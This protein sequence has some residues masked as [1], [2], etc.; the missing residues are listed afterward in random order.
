MKGKLIWFISLTAG[1]VLLMSLVVVVLDPFFHYHAPLKK[2]Y[3][4]LDDERSQS[5]GVA[6]FFD[7]DAVITGAG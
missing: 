7:Y 3:Y 5:I 4:R 6:R 1:L 2:Y